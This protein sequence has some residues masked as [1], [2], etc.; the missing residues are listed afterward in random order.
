MDLKDQEV[1]RNAVARRLSNSKP[2]R[3]LFVTAMYPHSNRPGWGTFVMH[4]AEQLRRGGLSID[5]LHILGY[6]SK[7]HYLKAVFDVFFRTWRGS[8]DIVHVH[9]GLC[10]IP[11]LFRWRTPLVI[12]LHG[13]DALSGKL[14]QYITR[15]VCR[16]VN[17]VIVVSK[18]IASII[19]GTVIPCGVDLKVFKPYDRLMARAKLG[20]SFKQKIILFP[21]DT[22]RAVKR[23]DLAKDVVEN[24]GQR[25]QDVQLLVVYNAQNDL[26]PFYYSAADAMILCSDSE[27][28]PT[29][30]KE[31]LACNTPVVSTR[32]GDVHEIFDGVV[33]NK[34]CD[35]NVEAL[36]DG[37]EEILQ[38]G[39]D[40]KSDY[41]SAMQKYNQES[42][43]E[44]IIKVYKK[45]MRKPNGR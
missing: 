25:G 12:T 34:I 14:Q 29:S 28:S 31:A 11:A 32:V 1:L 27:G 33:G 23:Y 24:L 13:S 6:R 22:R 7:L 2:L 40:F 36:A 30:V 39:A 42:T 21:F 9:Y 41:R 44:S 10:G 43:V 20:L 5:V 38:R 17:A 15:C 26:M 3:I 16:F 45:V 8:Y 18:E 4:Q 37:L 19:P 35:Q